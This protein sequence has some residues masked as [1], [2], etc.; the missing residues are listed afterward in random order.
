MKKKILSAL[1]PL[2][3]LVRPVGAA[4]GG[5]LLTVDEFLRVPPE[6]EPGA[7]RSLVLAPH[8]DDETLGCGGSIA[9]HGRA[10][11]E[12][13]VAFLTDGRLGSAQ[14]RALSGEARQLAE[15][16]LIE[17]R[18]QEA[19]LAL[20]TLGVRRHFFLDGIDGALA[21]DASVVRRLAE[22]LREVRPQIVY[23]PCFLEQ[24]PD[25]RA[26]SAIL[27][28]AAQEVTEDFTCHAYEVWTP[29]YPNRCVWI[30]EVVEIKKRALAHYRSQLADADFEHGMLGLNAY[31][32][33]LRPGNA[34]GRY[35]EAYC[36]LP[37]AEYRRLY[38]AYR[39]AADWS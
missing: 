17:T 38:D 4:F 13:A 25:H 35:A 14:L 34:R 18:K 26:A 33:M 1:A 31:R 8:M 19:L 15:Q 5:M 37:F 20:D 39:H 6:W 29:L 28:A 36:V 3:R 12:V 30:D 7:Q 10:G 16:A 32:S 9:L 11:G 22:V 27:I 21:G 23:L 24:H 2:A